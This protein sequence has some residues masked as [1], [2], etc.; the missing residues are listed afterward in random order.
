VDVSIVFSVNWAFVSSEAENAINVRKQLVPYN[1]ILT[2]SVILRIS[3][4][5]AA[6]SINYALE[7]ASEWDFLSRILIISK[8]LGKMIAELLKVRESVV[9]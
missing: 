1:R 2:S 7:N 3:S 5:G 6:N 9:L 4:S 8:Q